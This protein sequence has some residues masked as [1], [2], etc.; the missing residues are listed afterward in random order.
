VSKLLSEFIG[1][2][3]LV[4]AVVGSGIMATNLTDDVGL[5][6]VINTISTVAALFV[7]ISLFAQISGAHF[8]PVVSLYVVWQKQISVSTSLQYSIVQIIG[9]ICG[10]EFAELMFHE[11]LGNFSQKVR[12]GTGLWISEIL[13]TAVLVI[14]I[15]FALKNKIKASVVVPAWIGA[16]YLFT[17]STIFANPAVTIGRAFSDSFAGIHPNSTIGFI[18]AQLIGLIIGSVISNSIHKD[19]N[20]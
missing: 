3:L 10:A 6:L 9:A 17:S 11:S 20:V 19:S 7:L 14:I 12:S 16:G 18:I 4:C 2:F 8:N 13:A 5:Q 15:S 1:T